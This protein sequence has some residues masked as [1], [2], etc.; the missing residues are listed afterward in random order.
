MKA[1]L[2]DMDGTLIDSLPVLY[3]GYKGFLAFFGH[4]G[5]AAEFSSLIGP[6]L[7]EIVVHLQE[8][9]Q[10]PGTPSLLVQRYR[11]AIRS[12]Y[13]TGSRLFPD[14]KQCLE[15]VREWGWHI[16][17]VTSAW[18]TFAIENLEFQGIAPLFD[19]VMTPEDAGASKPHPEIYKAALAGLGVKAH[20]ALAIEDA[21]A[22]IASALGA[23]LEVIWFTQETEHPSKKV[24]PMTSWQSIR[25]FLEE[26]HGTV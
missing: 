4:E 21:E 3:E 12:H 20:E 14:A 1:L 19:L 25:A 10:L 18:R 8:K 13:V 16:A 17:L 9:Y 26:R 2:V 11:D 23:G 6:S 5:S 7:S 15:S 24:H 22:G